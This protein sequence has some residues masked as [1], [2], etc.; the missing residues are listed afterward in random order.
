MAERRSG[1]APSLS[2]GTRGR[3]WARAGLVYLAMLFFAVVLIGPI[4]FAA[5]SSVKTN[6]LEYPPTLAIPQLSPA[7]WSAA[8]RLGAA[9][10]GGRWFGGF[11]P[12]ADV[13]FRIT[14]FVPEGQ[15]AQAPEVVVSR[16]RSGGLQ[17]AQVIEF[18]ADY[19]EVSPVERGLEHVPVRITVQRRRDR[20]TVRHLQL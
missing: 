16:R 13:P 7:N 10:R 14:Y 11:A 20:R 2:V 8:A 15:Q 12:G 5:V 17:A 19:A 18:A 3:R 4:L 6:P 1:A 9:G